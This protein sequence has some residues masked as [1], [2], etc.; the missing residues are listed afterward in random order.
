M[1]W[2]WLGVVRMMNRLDEKQ[3]LRRA[4]ELE[5]KMGP[6]SLGFEWHEIPAH[7]TTLNKLVLQGILK[8]NFKSHSSTQYRLNIPIEEAEKVLEPET[9]PEPEKPLEDLF[10]V[11][12]GHE[13][14]RDLFNRAIVADKPVH[15]LMVGDVATAKS[16]FLSE[17][18][19]LPGAEL[20]LGGRST[21][22]GISDVLLDREPNILIIDEID[23][24]DR[25]DLS[26]LLSLCQD[27]LV[28]ETKHGSTRQARLNTKVFCAANTTKGL[29][30][31]VLSRFEILRF[32]RYSEDE[33][34]R[35]MV[36]VLTMREGVS[37]DLAEYVAEKVIKELRSQDPR[38]AIRVSRLAKTKEDVDKIVGII[39]GRALG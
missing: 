19:R 24:C 12:I 35:V 18:A 38:E 8:V 36:G 14:M 27:G 26:I 3:I 15:F 17:L 33:A 21:K 4:I 11:V 23:K 25:D 39:K 1:L 13:D 16:L 22:V 32:R 29:P 30:P 10:S 20:V 28:K 9:K 31:E 2:M 6:E 37:G 7:A 34:R 5:R